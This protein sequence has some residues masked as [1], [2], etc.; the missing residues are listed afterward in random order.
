VSLY[1]SFP[2]FSL[3]TTFVALCLSVSHCGR[4]WRASNLFG[5]RSRSSAGSTPSVASIVVLSPF[6]PFIAV[7]GG[8][9]YDYIARNPT[10]QSPCKTQHQLSCLYQHFRATIVLLVLPGRPIQPLR[11][12]NT[13]TRLILP[14]RARAI[15]RL[16]LQE[17]S[18]RNSTL[19]RVLQ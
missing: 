14:R 9:L 15:R 11:V 7:A 12:P 2:T 17:A 1:S 18:N 19:S 6:S 8:E 3:S 10:N 16:S 5:T 4:V 13:Y